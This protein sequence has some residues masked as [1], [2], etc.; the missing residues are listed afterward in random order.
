MTM[1]LDPELLLAKYKQNDFERAAQ[2]SRQV[3]EAKA[4]QSSWFTRPG[5]LVRGKA[6]KAARWDSDK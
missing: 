1:Q 5:S 4:N 3:R 6:A 2:R